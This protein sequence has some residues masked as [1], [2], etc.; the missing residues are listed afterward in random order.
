MYCACALKYNVNFKL[1][2]LLKKRL[3]QEI[4]TKQI[5][6]MMGLHENLNFK[7]YM[8]L[9]TFLS[10]KNPVA[11]CRLPYHARSTVVF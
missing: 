3:T 4:Y 5:K 6:K 8:N 1:D 11:T 9:S 7:T 10:L 2:N